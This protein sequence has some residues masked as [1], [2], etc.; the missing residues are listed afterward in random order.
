MP[1]YSPKQLTDACACLLQNP[2]SKRADEP[3]I[4]FK[5]P[6]PRRKTCNSVLESKIEMAFPHT[7]DFCNFYNKA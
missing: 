7:E 2:N 6:M 1:D 5:Y 4:K 3:A